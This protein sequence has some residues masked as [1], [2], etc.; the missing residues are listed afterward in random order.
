MLF[1]L[2]AAV[3]VSWFAKMHRRSHRSWEAIVA[4]MSPECRVRWTGPTFGR[5]E[6]LGAIWMKYPRTAFRDSGVLLEMV[7]YAER[8]ALLCD[9]ARLQVVRMA[10]LELR[11]AATSAMIRQISFR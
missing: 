2:I 3:M 11:M 10:A 1:L 7:D 5:A 9:S 6:A 8:N 4:R